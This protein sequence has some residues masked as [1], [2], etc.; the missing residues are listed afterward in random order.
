MNQ[1]ISKQ[2]RILALEPT[3]RGFG[4]C[5]GE[6]DAMLECGHKEVRGNKNLNSVSKIKKLMQQFLPAI[7]PL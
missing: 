4:Y 1:T 2:V 6:N 3:A 7:D 5:V